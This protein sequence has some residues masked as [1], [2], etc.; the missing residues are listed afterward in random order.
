MVTRDDGRRRL[1]I[2]ALV[3]VIAFILALILALAIA[4]GRTPVPRRTALLPGLTVEDAGTD[5]G[6][7]VTS[8]QSKSAAALA[9]I[10][11]GDRIVAIDQHPVASLAAARAYLGNDDR[12]II[13]L[14]LY[15]HQYPVSVRLI[16]PG[17]P[18]NVTQDSRHRG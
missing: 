9:G 14:Y 10:E 12:S 11:V 15:H 13:D 1:A 7:L 3:I 16:R 5:A 4:I 18:N 17:N 2:G 6:I 8:I